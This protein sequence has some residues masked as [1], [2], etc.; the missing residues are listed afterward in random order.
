MASGLDRVIALTLNLIA[1][2][3]GLTVSNIPAIITDEALAAGHAFGSGYAKKYKVNEL[4]SLATDFSSSGDTYKAATAIASQTP[5]VNEFY[6]IKRA[7]VVKAVMTLTFSANLVASNVVAGTVNGHAIS[8]TYASSNA[9]TLT[10][11]ASAIQALDEVLTATSNG[12]DTITITFEEQVEP[13]V[14]A[15]TVTLGASQATVTVATTTPA[16]NIVDDL[17]N[18]LGETATAS[19]WFMLLP[20]TTSVFAIQAAAEVIEAQGGAKMALFHTTQAA[21]ITSATTDIASLLKAEDYNYSGILYHDD[22]AEMAH[23]AWASRCLAVAPG[24]VSF[25]LKSLTG[26]TTSGLTSAQIGY[27]EGKNCNTYTDAGPGPLTLKGVNVAGISLEAIRDSI[28]A[29]GELETALYALFVARNKIPYNES[30]RQLVLA[31][32]N[33]VVS[34]M[35]SEGVFD[36]DADPANQFTMPEM[37]EISG[38]DKS[39]RLF[40]DCRLIGQHLAGAIKIEISADISVS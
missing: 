25:A 21:V 10:A 23:C 11:L 16:T 22:S 19:G 38:T 31:T 28:Y 4:S 39:N 29:K 34:R 8:V 9:A 7:S 36:P 32:A 27:A 17:T 26:C 1:G 18:A 24:S 37:T 35:V 20:T 12:T 13:S 30:G 14:G 5:K 2:A 40:P 3:V 6:V 15:F 33:A